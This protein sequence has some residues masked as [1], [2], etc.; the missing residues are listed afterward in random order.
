MVFDDGVGHW[1]EL[2]CLLGDLLAILRAAFVDGLPV[3]HVRWH[4]AMP[5]VIVL[6]SARVN[7]FSPAK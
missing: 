6:P 4:I 7:V 1:E 3:L 2:P 5:A